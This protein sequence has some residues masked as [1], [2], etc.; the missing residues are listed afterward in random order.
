MVKQLSVMTLAIGDGANDVAMV[1]TANIGVGL[2]EK[3][4]DKKRLC[5]QIGLGQFR[6]LTRLLLVHGRWS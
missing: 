5:H 3:K 4:E 2:P 1:Q 6:F